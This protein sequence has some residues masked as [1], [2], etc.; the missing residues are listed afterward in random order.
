MCVCV[1]VCVGVGVCVCVGV[2]GCA[3]VF[4]SV[5]KGKDTDAKQIMGFTAVKR[6]I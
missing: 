6:L 4:L 3:C 5:F 2:C 1:G